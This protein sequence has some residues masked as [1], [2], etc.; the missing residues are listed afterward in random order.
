MFVLL[1]AIR[2]PWDT[3]EDISLPPHR[4]EVEPTHQGRTYF[5]RSVSLDVLC[6]AFCTRPLKDAWLRFISIVKVALMDENAAHEAEATLLC[7]C[8]G[9]VCHQSPGGWL[10]GTS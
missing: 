2:Q 3:P 7:Q 9:P 10:K 8:R 6:V 5:D 4:C 1:S